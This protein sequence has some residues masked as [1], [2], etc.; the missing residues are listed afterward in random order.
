MAPRYAVQ[1]NRS[2]QRCVLQFYVVFVLRLR[3]GTRDQS[4]CWRRPRTSAVGQEYRTSV[5]AVWQQHVASDAVVV[6]NGFQC[7]WLSLV[8]GSAIHGAASCPVPREARRRVRGDA[9]R[10]PGWP[11]RFRYCA[12]KA[13]SE[14]RDAVSIAGRRSALP[15]LGAAR[16]LHDAADA[17]RYRLAGAVMPRRARPQL[18]FLWGLRGSDCNCSSTIPLERS[19]MRATTST[20]RCSA[21]I[22]RRRDQ[23]R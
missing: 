16:D 14:S 11:P 7:R 15:R 1:P 19:V 17:R 4:G 5:R 12:S 18:L 22:V 13:V 23:R 3:P 6:A 20:R 10:P 21:S 8:V 2:R 9:V